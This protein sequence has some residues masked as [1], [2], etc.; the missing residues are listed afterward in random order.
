MNKQFSGFSWAQF[1]RHVK[2]RVV[3]CVSTIFA[4]DFVVQYKQTVQWS[5]CCH[6]AVKQ[7]LLWV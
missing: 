1:A 7:G 2:E 4:N 6:L 3:M 5:P